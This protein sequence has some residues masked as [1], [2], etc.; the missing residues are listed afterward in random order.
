MHGIILK[1]LKDYIVEQ[2]DTETWADVQAQAGREGEMYVAVTT[3][4][5]EVTVELLD[6]ALDVTDTSM[7]AF[8][9]DWGEWI[10]EPIIDIY[11]SAYVEPHWDGLDLLSQIEAIHTQLRQ[12]RMGEMT[13]PVLR[14]DEID[15]RTLKIV[16]GS[17][18]QWCQWI[19]GLIEGV[20]DY[21]DEAYRYK[22]HTCMLEGDEQCTFSVQRVQN[23]EAA[24]QVGD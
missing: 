5:E 12:R 13:P 21:Y 23:P 6:A 20:G 24:G 14:I 15:D 9:Y 4:D 8:M 3:Y 10:I 19:P 2:Y 22:E 7:K 18:R 11:G 1:T 16:Y 17:Q